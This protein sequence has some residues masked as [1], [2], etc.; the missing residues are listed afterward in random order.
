MSKI[1]R[2]EAGCSARRLDLKWNTYQEVSNGPKISYGMRMSF[3]RKRNR[4]ASIFAVRTPFSNA[5][6][7]DRDM[8]SCWMVAHSRKAQEQAGSARWTVEDSQDRSLDHR[9]QTLD[10]RARRLHPSLEQ[11]KSMVLQTKQEIDIQTRTRQALRA[12]E[13]AMSLVEDK[14]LIA[15]KAAD[16]QASLQAKLCRRQTARQV[17]EANSRAAEQRVVVDTLRHK[18]EAAKG[19]TSSSVALFSGLGSYGR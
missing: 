4:H 5:V 8:S 13:R 11:K 6:A 2:Q 1:N 18:Q 3:Y 17:L 14:L 9:R 19:R 10:E 15:A 12:Q 16:E 7:E